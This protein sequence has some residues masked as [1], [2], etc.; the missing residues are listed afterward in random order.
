VG[1][2][3]AM[4]GAPGQGPAAALLA[5]QEELRR[6]FAR[7]TRSRADAQDLFQETSA[8]ML[9]GAPGHPGRLRLFHVA[10]SV[11]VDHLQREAVRDRGRKADRADPLSTPFDGLAIVSCGCVRRALPE[12]A[13]LERE[14]LRRVDLGGEPAAVIARGLGVSAAAMGLR[15]HRARKRLRRRLQ[16]HCCARAPGLHPGPPLRPGL[17]VRLPMRKSTREVDTPMRQAGTMDHE[18]SPRQCRSEGRRLA[19]AEEQHRR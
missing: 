3:R 16:A 7:R 10:R 1:G 2:Q 15:L 18:P 17:V 13:P 19:W 11:L 9:A 8:R 12:A 4:T 5:R 6:F 14:I